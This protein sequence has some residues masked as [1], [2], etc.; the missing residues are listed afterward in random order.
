M[1]KFYTLT[2]KKV[3][4]ETPEAVSVTFEVPPELKEV[5]TYKQGQYITLKKE[6]NGEEVR[7][8]YSFCSSPLTD[9]D[10]IIAVKEVPDG[11]LSPYINHQLKAGD[12]LEVMTPAGTF[13]TELDER[14]RKIYVGFAGGSGITPFMSI[15]KTTLYQ[16]PHSRF[17]VFYGNK[18]TDAIIF[19]EQLDAWEKEYEGR[20]KVIHILSDEETED[21]LFHGL[22]TPEKYRE[23]MSH[24]S[25]TQKANAYFICGPL[26][27]I[28]NG[29]EVL[30]DMGIPEKNVH[31]EL[32]SVP[33][34]D[35]KDEQENATLGKT[36]HIKLILDGET[37]EYNLENEWQ[38]ILDSALEKGIDAPYSCRGGICATCRA[39]LKAGYVRM[40][41]NYVLSDKEVEQGYILTCQ[42]IPETPEIVVDYDDQ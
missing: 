21:P 13:F 9:E 38:T 8:S 30:G 6:I 41:V 5:F 11:T 42:S 22:M 39:K 18:T 31:Y 40:K 7:R 34:D 23:L 29:I 24:Y 19:R 33:E 27:M 4:R 16:E 15:I 3:N 12:Q 25:H 32:F 2:V 35:T 26:P 14:N 10:L 1:A 36:T 17:I 37:Y 20:F 28:E